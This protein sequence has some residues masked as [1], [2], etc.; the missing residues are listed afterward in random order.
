M[1]IMSLVKYQ[2][3]IKL[4]YLM[5]YTIHCQKGQRYYFQNPEKDITEPEALLLF[6]RD[7]PETSASLQEKK[8]FFCIK[9]KTT[10]LK[11]I[12]AQVL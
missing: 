7:Y 11:N 5:L 12:T 10:Q 9:I 6:Y 1:A 4:F 3:K 8:V 2:M